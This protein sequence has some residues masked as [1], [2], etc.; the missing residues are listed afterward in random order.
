MKFDLLICNP[1]YVPRR[2]SIDDNPYEGV[3]LLYHLV[4]SGQDY[5]NP[6]GVLLINISS[7]CWNIVFKKKP[8]MKI[9]IFEKMEV[10]LKVNNI[11][12]N[13]AWLSYL[14]KNGLK[15]RYKNGY[16]YWQTLFIAMF[17][18]K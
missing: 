14:E 4:H 7:L 5:L 15:K 6:G 1:P 3:E 9:K 12:N 11:L 10:P 2:D 17:E 16:D 13:R 8:F 18:N